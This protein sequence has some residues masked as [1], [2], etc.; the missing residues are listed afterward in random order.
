MALCKTGIHTHRYILDKII[1][2]RFLNPVQLFKE[3]RAVFFMGTVVRRCSVE[4]TQLEREKAVLFRFFSQRAAKET[5]QA[6][7]KL[8]L[9]E[10]GEMKTGEEVKACKRKAL[11]PCME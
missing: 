4:A 9:K 5:A 10:G 6:S 11:L 2:K 7:E 1:L 8:S 3:T